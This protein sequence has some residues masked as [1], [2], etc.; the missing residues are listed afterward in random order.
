MILARRDLI[1]QW[2]VILGRRR[3]GTL[4]IAR[5]SHISMNDAP[6]VPFKTR[7]MSPADSR[8]SLAFS[9]VVKKWN[10]VSP[11]REMTSGSQ[12]L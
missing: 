3:A 11:S 6:A 7:M 10:S 8:H 12:R 2:W 5:A 1:L 4:R 9:P